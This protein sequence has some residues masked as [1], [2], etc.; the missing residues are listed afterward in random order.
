MSE[1]CNNFSSDSV[2]ILRRLKLCINSMM[3]SI[4][5][6]ILLHFEALLNYLKLGCNLMLMGF[7]LEQVSFIGFRYPA[8]F[9][10]ML[11]QLHFNIKVLYIKVL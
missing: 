10:I 6:K 3:C 4:V 1:K 7:E 5:I 2:R 8:K 11:L 9:V